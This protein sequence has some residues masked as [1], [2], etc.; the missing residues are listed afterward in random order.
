SSEH[1]LASVL[2]LLSL[3]EGLD[4]CKTSTYSSKSCRIGWTLFNNFCYFFSCELKSWE[5][6][7]QNCRQVGAD[8]V[9]VDTSEEQK[10]LS[11]NIKKETWIGLNDVETEGTWKWTDG[12][13]NGLGALGLLTFQNCFYLRTPP[14]PSDPPTRPSISSL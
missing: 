3:K 11:K 7:R 9:V 10:F 4:F 5:A 8:L 12:S 2:S 14:G 1:S 6:S 13:L